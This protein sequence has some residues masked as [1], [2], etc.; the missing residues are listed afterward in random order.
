MH[1]PRTRFNK[2]AR[3]YLTSAVHSNRAAL[4]RLVQIVKPQGGTVVD[5][6]TGAGHTAFAFAPHVDRVIATDITPNMLS[7]ARVEARKRDLANISIAFADAQALPFKNAS[8]SGITCRV[9]AHHFRD[10]RTFLAESYRALSPNGWFLMVDTAGSEDSEADEM[11]DRFERLRDP[12][13]VRNYP[14]SLWHR[15][16][17]DAG[18]DIEHQELSKKDI[19]S[20]DWMDRM[21]VAEWDRKILRATVQEAQGELKNY[22]APFERNGTQWFHLD[23]VIILARKQ[24]PNH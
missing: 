4:D 7:V 10:V 12:S 20:E 5:V 14:P 8:L 11:L 13:H 18:F 1:D 19:E 6:A 2:G 23:E 22:L 24:L 17:Q 21:Q 16:V 3:S 9:G 15:M